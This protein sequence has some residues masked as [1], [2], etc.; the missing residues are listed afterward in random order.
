MNINQRFAVLAFA[1]LLAMTAA[2]AQKVKTEK[3]TKKTSKTV[4][5]RTGETDEKITVE[6]TGDKVLINGKPADQYK[7]AEVE[8]ITAE[9]GE[10]AFVRG[11]RAWVAPPRPPRPPRAPRAITGM[12]H[13]FFMEGSNKAVLGVSM[14]S[15]EGGAKISEVVKGSAAEKA[16]LKEGDVITAL[17]DT[18]ISDA[19]DLYE[20]VGKYKEG[21]QV[22]VTYKRSDKEATVTATLQKNSNRAKTFVPGDGGFSFNFDGDMNGFRFSHGPRL[23]LQ[24]QDLEQGNGVKVLDVSEETPAAKAGLQKDDVII[25]FNGKDVKSVDDL[26]EAM[27]DV[28]PGDSVKVSYQRAGASRTADIIFPKQLKKASL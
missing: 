7:G 13:L 11:G 5:V 16:G 8:V 12:D 26:R 2:N 3:E 28:K 1:G 10:H 23:G 9:P 6:I 4:I 20:A 19:D 14:E 21:D 27:K 18:K 17:G 25:S 22:Q 24:I 15:V